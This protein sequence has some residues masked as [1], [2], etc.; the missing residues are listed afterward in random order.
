MGLDGW[1]GQCI[2]DSLLPLAGPWW[3]KGS[4]RERSGVDGDLLPF[5][6]QGRLDGHPGIPL[7]ASK[8]TVKPGERPRQEIINKGGGKR[9]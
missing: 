2:Y 8:L 7:V 5:H 4:T 1:S 3:I 9:W 6:V